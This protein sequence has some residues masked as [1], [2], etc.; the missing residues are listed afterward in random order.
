M[1]R[2]STP[3][4]ILRDRILGLD[5]KK[6]IDAEFREI[7]SSPVREV[8]QSAWV[9]VRRLIGQLFSGRSPLLARPLPRQKWAARLRW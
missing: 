8:T 3:H 2:F 1:H 7:K 9:S 6:V 4:F 5:A